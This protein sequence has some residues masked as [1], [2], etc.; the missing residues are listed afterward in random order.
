MTEAEMLLN[1]RFL[2]EAVSALFSLFLGIFVL[3]KRYEKPIGRVIAGIAFVSFYYNAFQILFLFFPQ[4]WIVRLG[5]AGAIMLIPILIEFPTVVLEGKYTLPRHRYIA[6]SLTAFF[7]AALPTSYMFRD[8][9]DPQASIPLALGGP[10]MIVYAFAKGAIL[11]R[12]FIIMI[13]AYKNSTDDLLK[14]RILF[15][16]VGEAFYALCSLHDVLLRQQIFWV[17]AFPIVEWATL[18][19]MLIVAYATLRYQL[20]EMDVFLSYGIYYFLLTVAIAGVYKVVENFLDNNLKQ[21]ISLNSYWGQFLPAFVIAILIQVL[22]DMVMR[23]IDRVF[24][25]EEQR[26][27]K[28]LRSP[29]IRFLFLDHRRDELVALR[30]EFNQVIESLDKELSSDKIQKR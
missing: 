14:R 28:I 11:L 6:L 29:D 21:F 2:S 23:L 1:F 15:I 12:I 8:T 30:D 5:Y 24:L 10:M 22:R 4:V 9:L 13:L 3:W 16:L 20:L 27:W 26:Q 25:T 7:L 18:S 17:F 19:F